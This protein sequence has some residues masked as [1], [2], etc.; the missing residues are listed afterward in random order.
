MCHLSAA[1]DLAPVDDPQHGG[2]SGSIA[3]LAWYITSGPRMGLSRQET[4][5]SELVLS[6]PGALQGWPYQFPFLI[7]EDMSGEQN[8]MSSQVL[9]W[10]DKW[11][12]EREP[13][14]WGLI[15]RLNHLGDFWGIPHADAL[16]IFGALESEHPFHRLGSRLQG[17]C[18]GSAQRSWLIIEWVILTLKLGEEE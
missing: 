15:N 14:Y 9:A 17:M 16:L 5:F 18:P 11:F 1:A 13:K 4:T 8:L 12:T 2:C 10:Q 3:H 6:A 7:G